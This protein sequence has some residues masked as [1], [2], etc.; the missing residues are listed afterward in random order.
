MRILLIST[1][2]SLRSSDSV[3]V[4]HLES[5]KYK[6]SKNIP[7]IKD[8][9]RRV[10][11]ITSLSDFL[12]KNKIDAVCINPAGG[13]YFGNLFRRCA[14]GLYE[15]FL[16]RQV[17]H[18]AK[19]LNLPL[20]VVDF[21]DDLTIHPNNLYLLEHCNLYFKRELAVDK[22]RSLE[23]YQG[24]FAREAVIGFRLNK[25]Y[26]D[27][28]KKMRPVSLGLWDNETTALEIADDLQGH[29]SKKKWDIFC[30]LTSRCCPLREVALSQLSELKNKFRIYVPAGR[31]EFLEYAKAL[32]QSTICL[33][34]SGLGW[35]CHRHYEAALFGSVPLMSRRDTL[36]Y[37][38]FEHGI[39]GFYYDPELSLSCQIQEILEEDYDF[40]EI[41][42]RA[43]EKLIKYHLRTSRAE[44]VAGE[45]ASLKKKHAPK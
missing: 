17:I 6:E 40:S 45:I 36:T 43:K 29:N 31:L 9:F 7:D 39:D 15:N 2:F 22:W 33:S 20:V 26:E 38:P 35:D 8:I 21:M 25:S 42:K 1:H 10:K 4:F 41:A 19:K 32:N 23:S 28:M 44:Y 5:R 18:T 11:S 14:K 37:K 3:E 27:I 30:S 16:N 12:L 13:G 34:P 24:G